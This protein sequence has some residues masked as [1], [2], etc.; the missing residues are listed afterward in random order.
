MSNLDVLEERLVEL[1]ERLDEIESRLDELP[2]G[3]EERLDGLEERL[4]EIEPQ[5]E[6]VIKSRIDDTDQV[7]D[8]LLEFMTVQNKFNGM[9]IRAFD[10]EFEK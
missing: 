10:K 6:E 9:L 5:D 4:D 7:V 2:Y 1:E 3:V 8:R